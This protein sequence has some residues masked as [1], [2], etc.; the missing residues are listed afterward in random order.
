ML[1][2]TSPK[3]GIV[4]ICP[5]YAKQLESAQH[6]PGKDFKNMYLKIITV[7]LSWG[8]KDF[9]TIKLML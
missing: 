3:L 4:H 8:L 9:G 7:T 6:T 1:V 2:Y 5:V